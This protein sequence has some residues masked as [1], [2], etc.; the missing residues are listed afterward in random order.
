MNKGVFIIKSLKRYSKHLFIL[1]TSF[2]LIFSFQFNTFAVSTSSTLRFYDT[3]FKAYANGLSS[4][5][6]DVTNKVTKSYS[7]SGKYTSFS[8][9]KYDDV[10]AVGLA[11]KLDSGFNVDLYPGESYSFNFRYAQ[12]LNSL[13]WFKLSVYYYTGNNPNSSSDWVEGENLF[14]YTLYEQFDNTFTTWKNVNGTFT[15]PTFNSSFY[16]SFVLE[17][18]NNDVA[19]SSLNQILYL[20]DFSYS[21]SS[22]LYGEHYNPPDTNISSNID[23]YND[24]VSSLP[25]VDSD[26]LSDLMSSFDISDFSKA[27]DCFNTVFDNFISSLNLTHVLLFTLTFGLGIYVLGRRLK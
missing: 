20:G 27:F 22:P 26:N 3:S 2:I 7:N 12:R 14:I 23:D 18:I 6:I 24:I 21:L 9:P 11:L 4:D 5:K 19:G 15:V 13:N 25:T 8:F 10:G 16:S 17:Y 1:L